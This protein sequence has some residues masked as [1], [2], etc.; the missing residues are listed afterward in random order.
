M[1]QID[2]ILLQS[3]QDEFIRYLFAQQAVLIPDLH[4][5]TKGYLELDSFPAAIEYFHKKYHFYITHKSF[6]KCPLEMREMVK[7][8]ISYYYIMPRNGGPAIDILRSNVSKHLGIYRVGIGFL[9]YY[10][11]YWD[12]VTEENRKPP[13]ELI[14][15]YKNISNFIKQKTN[16]IKIL[17]ETFLVSKKLLQDVKNEGAILK[18][19]GILWSPTTEKIVTEYSGN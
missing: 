5:E 11:T 13:I 18:I 7:N 2:F 10:P 14:N 4:F 15:F 3:E 19:N 1:P 6:L 9:S 12:T 8:G 17:K 16:R